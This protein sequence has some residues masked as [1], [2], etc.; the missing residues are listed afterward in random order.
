MTLA[1][2]RTAMRTIFPSSQAELGQRM[3]KRLLDAIP[4]LSAEREQ[5][6]LATYMGWMVRG[7][8]TADSVR[9]LEDALEVNRDA[10]LIVTKNLKVALQDDQRCL[11]MKE[12]E[13]RAD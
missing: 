12:L 10:T 4:Q 1:D 9:L 6:Y 8:C 13:S 7:W 11:A 2:A 3:Q 5:P